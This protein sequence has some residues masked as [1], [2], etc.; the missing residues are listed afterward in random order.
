MS[1]T[2]FET[3]KSERTGGRRH[4]L[5]LHRDDAAPRVRTQRR[6]EQE[7]MRRRSVH[8]A[9]ALRRAAPTDFVETGPGRQRWCYSGEASGGALDRWIRSPST[10]HRGT[11]LFDGFGFAR[12]PPTGFAGYAPRPDVTRCCALASRVDLAAPMPDTAGDAPEVDRPPCELRPADA[13]GE[14]QRWLRFGPLA[15]TSFLAD[16]EAAVA[17]RE[18]DAGE[19][20]RSST[21]SKKVMWWTRARTIQPRGVDETSRRHGSTC[22]R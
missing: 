20:E 12:G 6:L 13:G 15:D 11:A 2:S 3:A 10:D 14:D 22:G 9:S 7:S 4:W 21:S 5:V 17:L 18:A 16:A 1:A 8:R 19:N